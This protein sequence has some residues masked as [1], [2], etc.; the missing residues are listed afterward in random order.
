MFARRFGFPPS[1]LGAGVLEF[2]VSNPAVGFGIRQAQA[3]RT[4][5]ARTYSH[6]ALKKQSFIYQVNLAS[7]LLPA[8]AVAFAAAAPGRVVVERGGLRVGG[9]LL[10]LRGAGYDADVPCALAR[11]LPLLAGMGANVVRTPSVP[12]RAE[13]Y[14]LPLLN[15]TG[16][17]WI[18]GFPVDPSLPRDQVL[19][20]F[21]RYAERFRGERRLIAIVFG[22]GAPA[23]ALI[24]DAAAILREIDGADRPLVATSAAEAEELLAE[25][26]GL[27]FW[28]WEGASAPPS[29]GSRP[30]LAGALGAAAADE[31]VQA[32]AAVRLAQDIEARRLLG[33]VWKEFAGDSGLVRPVGDSLEPRAVFYRLAALWGG[34][35]PEAWSHKAGPKLDRVENETALSAGSLIRIAGADLAPQ[36]APWSDERWPLVLGQNCL[37][38]DGIPA[39]L[40]F[41]SATS[42]TAQIPAQLEPGDRTLVFYRAGRASNPVPVRIRISA[43]TQAGPLIDA[44]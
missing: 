28:S 7:W 33:G 21:R 44:E 14:F 25:V 18:S 22:A 43:D 34:T 4:G 26:P 37:C 10:V 3:I 41:V 32:A 12:P 29:A 38:V 42:I 19:R 17:Y 16:L 23:R 8:A 39:R 27:D 9:R 20:Q 31:Q 1:A 35:Y 36:T 40:S 5:R 24:P 15:S 11:D 6:I 13:Q 30:I 2:G